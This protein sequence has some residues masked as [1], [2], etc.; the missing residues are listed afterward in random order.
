MKI[1]SC[2][3]ISYYY[4]QDLV[5][6]LFCSGF[7]RN[8]DKTHFIGKVSSQKRKNSTPKF[9]LFWFFFFLLS[10]HILSFHF[11]LHELSNGEMIFQL[12]FGQALITTASFQ[13]EFKKVGDTEEKKNKEKEKR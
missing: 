9:S 1:V 2:G 3:I 7:L 6:H 5:C 11:V 4:P 13:V 10:I 8:L 12:H